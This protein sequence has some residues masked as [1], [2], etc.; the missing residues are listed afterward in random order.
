MRDLA[1]IGFLGVKV[2]FAHERDTLFWK[3]QKQNGN[4]SPNRNRSTAEAYPLLYAHNGGKFCYKERI[5]TSRKKRKKT[6]VSPIP[7][8]EKLYNSTTNKWSLVKDLRAVGFPETNWSVLRSLKFKFI[9]NSCRTD[10]LFSSFC[11]LSAKKTVNC[12]T[13]SAL[14]RGSM[15]QKTPWHE[16]DMMSF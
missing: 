9:E 10:G 4:L 7:S 14:K 8:P 11:F 6:F 1:L 13:V 2:L 3:C 5:R 16:W 12:C 15:K